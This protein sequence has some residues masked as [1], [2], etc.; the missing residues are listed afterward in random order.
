MNPSDC[1]SD[2]GEG[3]TRTSPQFC[4]K[5][6][7]F[8]T[9]S[10]ESFAGH[11]SG[12]TRRGELARVLPPN[13]QCKICLQRFSSRIEVTMHKPIHRKFEELRTP[14][15]RKARLLKERGH[16]CEICLNSEW[17]GRE[18]PLHID[19]IDGN[20]DNNEKSNFRLLCPNCHAQTPTYSG[21]NAGK[22]PAAQRYNKR[23]R[24]YLMA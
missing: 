16:R 14:G 15:S 13:H 1:D 23:K 4:C 3:R 5:I 22:F 2:N 10:R 9:N 6:C 7:G 21:R 12:H 19:H 11:R 18:I 24:S 8:S 20:S 17:M